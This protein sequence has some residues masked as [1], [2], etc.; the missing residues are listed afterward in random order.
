MALM[1]TLKLGYIFALFTFTLINIPID[2]L[3]W[4]IRTD[5]IAPWT[6]A[7]MTYASP[8]TSRAASAST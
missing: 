4:I 5:F 6:L 1:T 3:V 7:D 8:S 2:D